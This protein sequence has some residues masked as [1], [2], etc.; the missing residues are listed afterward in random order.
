MVLPMS[1]TPH[2]PPPSKG[3]EWA[4]VLSLGTLVGMGLLVFFI[5]G[6][7]QRVAGRKLGKEITTLQSNPKY[8]DPEIRLEQ[9]RDLLY[10]Y[11]REILNRE[12]LVKERKRLNQ[13]LVKV[14]EEITLFNSKSDLTKEEREFHETRLT[15]NRARV[16]IDLRANEGAM[17]SISFSEENKR[18]ACEQYREAI[19]KV[20]SVERRAVWEED[21]QNLCPQK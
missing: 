16:Q 19:Q 5:T 11:D 6:M 18:K 20:H 12:G 9:I 10:Q 21:A 4:W 2:T 15:R 8:Q 17:E 1:S 13:E 3:T 14:D 7:V